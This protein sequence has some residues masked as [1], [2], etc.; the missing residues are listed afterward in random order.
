MFPLS[1][2]QQTPQGALVE[3]VQPAAMFLPALTM[4]MSFWRRAGYIRTLVLIFAGHNNKSFSLVIARDDN[5]LRGSISCLI[6]STCVKWVAKNLADRQSIFV[7]QML[8][9][10]AVNCGVCVLEE[11]LSSIWATHRRIPIVNI[12]HIIISVSLAYLLLI[13]KGNSNFETLWAACASRFLVCD[14]IMNL[15]AI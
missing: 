1:Q 15:R 11:W 13:D 3:I 2:C 6:V 7:L 5:S 14:R 10:F 8:L 12:I 4:M 9:R